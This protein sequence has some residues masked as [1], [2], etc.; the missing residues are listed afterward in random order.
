MESEEELGFSGSLMSLFLGL[1]VLVVITLMAVFS[2]VHG[3]GRENKKDIGGHRA[4]LWFAS[5]GFAGG[6][7]GNLPGGACG[8]A[9]GLCGTRG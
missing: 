3:G 1:V 8:G 4:D 9:G 5:G 7:N 6:S 2:C